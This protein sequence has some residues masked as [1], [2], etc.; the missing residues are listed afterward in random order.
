MHTTTRIYRQILWFIVC[1]IA[2][3]S[4]GA[5]PESARVLVHTLNYIGRDYTGAVE[6]GQIKSNTEYQE[7]LGF[8][9]AARKYVIENAANWKPQDAAHVT[10]LVKTL[11]SLVQLKASAQQVS[12]AATAAK[13][14]VIKISKLPI[15]PVSYPSIANGKA[16]YVAQ[17]AKC[18]GMGGLGDGKEG[19]ALKPPPRNFTDAHRMQLISPFTAFN[20][21]RCGIAG[22]GMKAHPELS[23]EEVWD[24]AFYVLTIRH[25][26]AVPN[27]PV[28]RQVMATRFA[29]LQLDEIASSTDEEL[30]KKYNLRTDKELALIRCNSP[31]QRKDQFIDLAL[32]YIDESMQA[33]TDGRY[34]DAERLS[35]MAYLEGIEPIEKQLR[36]S[37]P[38]LMQRLEDQVTNTRRSIMAHR[39]VTEINDS[40]KVSRTLVHEAKGVLAEREV[41]GWL[42]FVMTTSIMLREGLE[43]FLVILVI[44]GVLS[45]SGIKRTHRWVHSGWILAVLFGIGLWFLGAGIIQ[46]NMTHIELMEGIVS[47]VAIGI[48]LYVGFWLHSKSEVTRWKAYVSDQIKNLSDRRNL[49]GLCLLSFFVV[50]R[51]VFESVLF[52]SALNLESAGKQSHAILLG[53]ISSFIVVFVLAWFALKYSTRLPI[54]KLF[55]ISSI[56]MGILAVILAGKGVHAMQETGYIGIHGLSIMPRI[57]LLGIFPTMETTL[58]QVAI[59]A[60]VLFIFRKQSPPKPQV[61]V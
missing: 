8:A 28:S 20:T 2:L 55:R 29:S 35:T 23:D 32:K 41:S 5:N 26:L 11:D 39:P 31:E 49:L 4:H 54:P 10:A 43:A 33:Y 7:M 27:D 46:S 42:A 19:L 18:H 16:V 25:P 24:V 61:A 60:L 22:T 47:F 14:E 9:H 21:V 53:V 51:E 48:L 44:L 30:T 59:G 52:L 58:F 1:L 3:S 57:E 6:Q 17:C 15:V 40:I 50:F 12:T 34:D 38:D 45:A 37:D 13:N 56:V 36:A